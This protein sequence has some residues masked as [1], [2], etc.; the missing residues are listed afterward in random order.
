MLLQANPRSVN[1]KKLSC[2]QSV[3]VQ[4]QTFRL[5]HQNIVLNKGIINIL[6]FSFAFFILDKRASD[7][8]TRP[9]KLSSCKIWRCKSY[10]TATRPLLQVDSYPSQCCYTQGEVYFLPPHVYLIPYISHL[11]QEEKKS[12]SRLLTIVGSLKQ[13]YSIHVYVNVCKHV[14]IHNYLITFKLRVNSTST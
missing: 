1:K 14:I 12:N 4:S 8:C 3:F 10:R 9:R 2:K 5:N 6:K 7:G 11:T 13:K